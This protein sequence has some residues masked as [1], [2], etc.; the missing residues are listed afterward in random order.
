VSVTLTLFRREFGAF[1]ITPTAYIIAAGF[2]LFTGVFFAQEFQ[3]AAIQRIPINPATIPSLI[4]YMLVF[5]APLFTMRLFAEEKREGTVELLLTA[6]VSEAS[7]VVAK[8]AAAWAYVTLLLGI[9]VVYQAILAAF[10]PQDL[11]HTLLAYIGIWLYSGAVLSIGMMFSALTENQIV[12]AFF[13]LL[14]LLILYVGDA[15]AALIGN[16]AI[17]EVVQE[18][19]LDSHYSASFA[20]GLF[21]AEDAA[22]FAGIIVI[23]LFLTMRIL[24]SNRWR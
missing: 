6:P 18:L 22:F 21:K 16:L 11:G 24:E 1:F 2:M 17:A 14:T 10:A 8:F 15:V 20:A 12:A 9:T 7:I 5:F 19:S 4:S 23:M 3:S 13:S